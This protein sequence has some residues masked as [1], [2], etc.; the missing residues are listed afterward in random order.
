MLLLAVDY[1][2]DGSENEP[3]FYD[4][5]ASGHLW[6]LIVAALALLL[7]GYCLLDVLKDRGMPQ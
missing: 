4:T 5:Y 1:I 7:G 2:G 6:V 3:G